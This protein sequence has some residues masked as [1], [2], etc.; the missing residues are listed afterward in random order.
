[1]R[2]NQNHLT[3]KETYFM[4]QTMKRSLAMFI[5]VVMFIALVPAFNLSVSAADDFYTY[6]SQGYIYNWGTR[7]TT[8][9]F[10]SP[11]A[12]KFYE[13]NNTSYDELSAYLGSDSVSAVPSSQLYRVLQELMAS[14]HSV[15]PHS[16][17]LT[18]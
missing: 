4:K 3:K 2:K 1:M 12:E 8:A 7:G 9:T 6:S 18:V 5:V 17:V 14:N 10:L 15:C 11:N 13:D 16:C